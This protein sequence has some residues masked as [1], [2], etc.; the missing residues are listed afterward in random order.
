MIFETDLKSETDRAVTDGGEDV[1][2]EDISGSDTVEI[3]ELQMPEMK[4]QDPQTETGTL[5]LSES[6]GRAGGV[7]ICGQIRKRD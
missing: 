4:A 1:F 5:V 7:L 6:T 3:T 2:A